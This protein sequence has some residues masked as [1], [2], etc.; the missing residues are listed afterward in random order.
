MIANPK[1]FHESM[2]KEPKK[3]YEALGF[4]N[5]ALEMLHNVVRGEG[6]AFGAI[7]T[8]LAIQGEANPLSHLLIS[9]T[10]GYAMV[11]HIFTLIHHQSNEKV[12]AALESIR[13]LYFMIFLNGAI[14]GSSLYVYLTRIK[15]I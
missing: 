10:T 6:A 3:V 8:Y 1:N 13:P 15:A 14:G 12:M 11:S 2:F 4:S 7:S 9:I 5:V